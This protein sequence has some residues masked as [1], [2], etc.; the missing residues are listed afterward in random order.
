MSFS[1]FV[2]VNELKY[3]CYTTSTEMTVH[4]MTFDELSSNEFF[5]GYNYIEL[6]RLG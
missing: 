2:I 3:G 4:L 1:C 6:V 5:G